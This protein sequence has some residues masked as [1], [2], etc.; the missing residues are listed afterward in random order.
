MSIA[1]T[2]QKFKPSSLE[3]RTNLILNDEKLEVITD[4]LEGV[5]EITLSKGEIIENANQLS[6]YENKIFDA[7]IESGIL[8]QLIQLAN[9]LK[10]QAREQ[11]KNNSSI[12]AS[13]ATRDNS[14]ILNIVAF[15]EDDKIQSLEI[16]VNEKQ[17]NISITQE[18]K[19]LVKYCRFLKDKL[20]A[21]RQVSQSLDLNHLL[22]VAKLDVPI[23]ETPI[24]E[25]IESYIEY[26]QCL[27]RGYVRTKKYLE[28]FEDK[29]LDYHDSGQRKTY[30]SKLL[31]IQS[32][33]GLLQ[34]YILNDKD[35][36]FVPNSSSEKGYDYDE[37]RPYVSKPPHLWSHEWIKR[38]LV[39]LGKDFIEQLE[40]KQNDEINQ[41]TKTLLGSN[42]DSFIK[43]NISVILSLL[44]I[45]VKNSHHVIKLRE[46]EILSI[47]DQDE[48]DSNLRATG[49]YGK[50]SI[51]SRYA[52][53]FWP[54]TDLPVDI[55]YIARLEHEKS[56]KDYHDIFSQLDKISKTKLFSSISYQINDFDRIL[57]AYNKL[58]E[59]EFCQQIYQQT[60]KS[61]QDEAEKL[62]VILADFYKLTQEP[63]FKSNTNILTTAQTTLSESKIQENSNNLETKI[64]LS[65]SFPEPITG[66]FIASNQVNTDTQ[67]N[68]ITSEDSLRSINS[69]DIANYQ[70]KLF[71]EIFSETLEADKVLFLA[72]SLKFTD[73]ESES[74]QY[75]G[76]LATNDESHQLNY[77]L[78]P[79]QQNQYNLEF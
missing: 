30:I 66:I 8:E 54:G 35:Y 15:V 47:V 4:N 61:F 23:M 76:V 65:S 75:S 77:K 12:Q 49:F 53:F 71:Q 5:K 25:M 18:D 70:N 1:F 19:Y 52:D 22:K 64:E 46:K 73:Q 40:Q 45:L 3:T 16:S 48:T 69:K 34:P 55:D 43:E 10:L 14:K 2:S 60:V 13:L 6:Q 33:V 57:K 26:D 44:I 36:N 38:K 63:I 56:S 24:K 7:V 28:D 78:T 59:Q 20:S 58:S 31:R 74:N 27:E 39:T 50:Y 42:N 67:L 29:V 68:F 9:L 32:D 62:E 21:T 11:N 41:L 72:N 37:K 17:W 79:I 51:N